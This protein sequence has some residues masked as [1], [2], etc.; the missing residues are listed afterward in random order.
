MTIALQKNVEADAVPVAPSATIVPLSP[1]R[2]SFVQARLIPAAKEWAAT[3]IPPIITIGA[4]LVALA[5]PLHEARR[6]VA[7]ADRASGPTQKI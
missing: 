5:D 1:P 2:A 6:N 7:V 3:L 4:L